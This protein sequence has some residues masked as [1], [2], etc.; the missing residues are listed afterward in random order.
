MPITDNTFAQNVFKAGEPPKELTDQLFAT[1][2]Q[3]LPAEVGDDVILD[4]VKTNVEIVKNYFLSTEQ[5]Q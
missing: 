4:I 5:S 2:R 3:K 1:F